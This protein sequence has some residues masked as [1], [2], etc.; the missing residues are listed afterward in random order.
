MELPPRPLI[1][2]GRARPMQP[3]PST[4]IVNKMVAVLADEGSTAPF[5]LGRVVELES[6][7]FLVRWYDTNPPGLC[8]MTNKL[9]PCTQILNGQVRQWKDWQSFQHCG[10]I[11][12]GFDLT[13]E[14]KLPVT[15]HRS[16]FDDSRVTRLQSKTKRKRPPFNIVKINPVKQVKSKTKQPR[17]ENRHE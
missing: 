7:R 12:A 13:G 4:V 11:V 1:Y 9:K 15:H 3:P 16:I 8:P 10:I 17:I 2:D 14:E 5:W 6:Q